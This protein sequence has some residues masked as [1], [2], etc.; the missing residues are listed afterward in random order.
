MIGEHSVAQQF[1]VARALSKKKC[2]MPTMWKIRQCIVIPKG[3]YISRTSLHRLSHLIFSNLWW[4]VLYCKS[5]FTEK[6]T[7]SGV[8]SDLPQAQTHS[9]KGKLHSAS[10]DWARCQVCCRHSLRLPSQMMATVMLWLWQSLDNK[11]PATWMGCV[12]A[13]G[14]K[15]PWVF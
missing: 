13:R 10:A 9:W 3:K 2:G 5:N 15:S 12:C 14:I 11:S 6:E 1:K 7:G 8:S 4:N